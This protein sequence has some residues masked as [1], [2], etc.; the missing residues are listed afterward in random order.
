VAEMMHSGDPV[1]VV[2]YDFTW[3][4]AF[5]KLAAR[6]RVAL[7]SLVVTVDHVGSTAVAGLA[8]KP[9]IDLD[10]VLASP[11]DER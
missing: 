11:A 6:V 3:P 5:A 2:D 4:D 8:A 7:G 10:V 1:L 9:I